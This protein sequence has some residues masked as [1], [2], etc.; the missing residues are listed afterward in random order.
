[1]LCP[2]TAW[3]AVAI[4]A[5]PPNIITSINKATIVRA[6]AA[7]KDRFTPDTLHN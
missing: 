6:A 3:P 2:E 7:A 1:M 5:P 4:G